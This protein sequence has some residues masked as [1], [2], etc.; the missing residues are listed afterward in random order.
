MFLFG[1]ETA[2]K[3]V[4]SGHGTGNGLRQKAGDV[5]MLNK[6]AFLKYYYS[7]LLVIGATEKTQKIMGC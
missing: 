4:V 2:N 3:D 5:S 7:M 1:N 6:S